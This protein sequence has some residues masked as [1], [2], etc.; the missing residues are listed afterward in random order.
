M[1]LQSYANLFSSLTTRIRITDL[2]G[3]FH[4]SPGDDS[5][6]S[7]P[8][9]NSSWGVLSWN[10]KKEET[11]RRT[12]F[13]IHLTKVHT[14]RTMQ[15]KQSALVSSCGLSAFVHKGESD[16]HQTTF[17]K[18]LLMVLLERAFR[19]VEEENVKCS[20]PHAGSRH[21]SCQD[22]SGTIVISHLNLFFWSQEPNGFK[23]AK[24]SCAQLIFSFLIF[25]TKE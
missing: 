10:K 15:M 14:L 7:K 9:L 23:C 8:V 22:P 2:W 13:G 6:I 5:V 19:K 18:R 17:W 25:G 11:E 1:Q 3:K 24:S 4:L 20:H 12:F 16:R 21:A